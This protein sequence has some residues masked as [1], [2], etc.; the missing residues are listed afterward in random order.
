MIERRR[1]RTPQI[2]A[3]PGGGLRVTLSEGEREALADLVRHLR[4]LLAAGPVQ[5]GEENDLAVSVRRRLFPPAYD[6]PLDQLEY[7]ELNTGSLIDGRLAALDAFRD[8]L[9]AGRARG[10]SWEVKLDA[11]QAGSWLSAVNDGRLILG[12]AVGIETEED[13]DDVW[14]RP[15]PEVMMLAYLGLLQEELV[16]ALMTALPEEGPTP[17]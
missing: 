2:R 14:D 5:A 12:G 8:S 17:R 4:P 1:A 15:E 3:L 13:W 10:R 7:T 6:D 11:Q 9:A 16:T